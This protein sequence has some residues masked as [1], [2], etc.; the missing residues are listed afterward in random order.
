MNDRI[1]E[2]PFRA[3]FE[4]FGLA[5]EVRTDDPELFR[6][7]PVAL[8]EWRPGN[9]T[10]PTA[11][12]DLRSDGS[13]FFDGDEL[14]GVHGVP[15]LGA[16]SDKMRH[17][18]ALNA[19]DHVFVHAGVVATGGVGIVVP[20]ASFSGKSTLVAALLRAGATY[21]SDEYAVVDGEGLIHPY[22]RPLSLRG[23]GHA[24]VPDR[25]F[26]SRDPIRAGLIVVTCYVP[27]ATWRPVTA[28]SGEGAMAL[29]EHMAAA[30]SASARA[31]AAARRV[32]ATAHVITGPRGEAGLAAA[33]LLQMAETIARG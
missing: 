24:A 17:H 21:Y 6:Q 19:P 4:S 5:V 13:L 23:Q 29:L 12:F 15:P 27:D 10:R 25:A 11:R 31:L 26:V 18:L 20:G 32:A 3:T 33:A 14:D 16:L 1:F 28:T 8:V 30:R 7:L 22:P 2:Y 9:G